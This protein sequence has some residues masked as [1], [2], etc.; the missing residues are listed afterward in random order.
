MSLTAPGTLLVDGTEG[1]D[2]LS[3]R[4]RGPNVDVRLNG[5]RQTFVAR[6][7]TRIE[8]Q[9]YAGNDIVD[10]SSLYIPTYINAGAG[11]DRVYAGFGNDTLTGASGRDQLFGGAGNDRINGGVH[12][13]RIEG[14]DGD[15][16]LYGGLGNDYMDGQ[17]GSDRLFGEDGDDMLIGGVHNDGLYGGGGRDTLMGLRGNDIL[18]GD[19]GNDILFGGLGN[20]VLYG[21]LGTDALYGEDGD[22]TLY[23]K[24]D[25]AVDTLDGGEGTDGGEADNNDVLINTEGITSGTPTP[26]PPPPMSVG[27]PIGISFNDEALWPGNF[28]TAVTEAKK[29]GV[30]VVRVWIDINDYDDRPKAYDP[31]NYE[32][33]VQKWKGW[34]TNRPDTAGLALQRA[35]DLKQAGFNVAVTMN[36]YDG[37]PPE[38]AQ[39]IKDFYTA[40]LNSTK[41]PGGGMKLKD[42]IDYW[43]IGN[44]VDLTGYWNPPGASSKTERIEAYVDQVLLPVSEVLHA[45]PAASREKVMSASVSWSPNDLNTILQRLKKLNKLDAIDYAAYHPYGD[46]AAVI[47]RAKRARDFAAAVGKELVATEWNVRG[48]ALDGS[49][50]AQ[51]AAAVDDLYRN[52]IAPNFAFA[53][54]YA[55]VDN[56]DARG[57]TITARPASVLKHNTNMSISPSSSVQDLIDW[58]NTPLVKNEPF[59][60]VFDGWQDLKD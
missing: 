35:F 22:D 57:G 19:G 55:L 4:Y 45:G 30:N 14:G 7:I 29:L 11:D 1:D 27:D 31:V 23:G 60:S 13:D 40:L 48:F 41:T 25:G 46:K 18:S 44:E 6:Q 39:E 8:I 33:I 32:H 37:Q 10:W 17:V 16:V 20:D 52:H 43:E 51:W 49:Q 12:N 15:D 50:D 58:Y 5:V 3:I 36:K 24:G 59:Y 28:E 38:N 56:F 47:D 2:V 9:T 21:G 34:S 54:Y 42:A 53:F 26:P